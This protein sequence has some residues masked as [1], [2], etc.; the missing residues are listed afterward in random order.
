MRF[1]LK[2]EKSGETLFEDIK[3]DILSILLLLPLAILLRIVLIKNNVSNRVIDTVILACIAIPIVVWRVIK[4]Q[5]P[6]FTFYLEKL[7]IENL[8]KIAASDKIAL[9]PKELTLSNTMVSHTFCANW[10]YLSI[11]QNVRLTRTKNQTDFI[12]VGV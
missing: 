5:S 8:P 11:N 10:E 1:D 6:S 2:I 4:E 12:W 3:K 7:L 9:Y